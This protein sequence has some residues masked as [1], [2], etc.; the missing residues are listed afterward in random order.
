MHAADN[1]P[2]LSL[3]DRGERFGAPGRRYFRLARA[4]ENWIIGLDR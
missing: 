2:A 4:N 1:D 3:H